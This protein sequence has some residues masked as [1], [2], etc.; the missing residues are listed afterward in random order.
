LSAR[1][2]LF[3]AYFYPPCADTG[4]HRP[5][6][7][8][9]YLRRLGHN[10]TVLTTSA[11]G[12]LPGERPED[13]VRTRDLQRVRARM[14][15]ADR[16]EGM[17]EA[18]TYSGRPHP[19]SYVL[20]PEPLVAAWVPFARRSAIRL[21]RAHRFD[22]V[23]T[24]S[25]PESAHLIGRALERRGVAWVAD[26]RDAWTFEPLRPRFP[27]ALQRWADRRLERRL[28]RA[29]DVVS[30]V[31]EPV[32]DDMRSRVGAN[33]VVVP[34]GWDPEL[35]PAAG[36]D[37][38]AD[39][40]DSLRT[41]LVYTGRFGSYGRDPRPLVE[42]LKRLA[43]A[44]PKTA[45]RLELA[46]AGPL[47]QDEA[48]LFDADVSPARMSLLGS[49]SHERALALQR[50]ADALLLIAAPERSQLANLKL[51]EYFA[52]GRPI[53]AL[54]DGTEAGRI[55]SE[56]R[57]GEVVRADDPEAIQRALAI[58]ATGELPEP[59]PARVHEYAYPAVAER[60][61]E[62]VELARRRRGAASA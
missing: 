20:V 61:E 28:M 4:A 43:G 23:I 37:V 11:Y 1:S 15:G 41:S 42:A 8:V 40:L 51:F 38:T 49:L 32:A 56:A 50:A 47:T 45:A 6:A 7:M 24:S 27:T 31:S 2:I 29:A 52:A 33:A 35:T 34:N 44:D 39:L 60:M 18:D 48:N 9:K 14:R 26:L 22:C 17:F 5:A 36:A 25:P 46:V 21:H 57:A 55:V 54:A 10:V 16:V 30:C 19:L 3:V 53:L 13:V 12:S 58:T 59:D 62:A